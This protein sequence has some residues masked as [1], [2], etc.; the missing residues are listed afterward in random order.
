MALERTVIG[1]G[2]K[3]E[4]VIAGWVSLLGCKWQ[5]DAARAEENCRLISICSQLTD[6]TR[7]MA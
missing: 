6:N 5:E 7:T 2:G 3:K 4:I 1:R